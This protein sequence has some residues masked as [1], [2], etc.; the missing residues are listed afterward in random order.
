MNAE[1]QLKVQALVDGELPPNEA[2]QVEALLAGD[3][4]ARQLAA[5]LKATRD[6]LRDNEPPLA[7]PESREFYWSKIAREIE[8]LEAQNAQPVPTPWLR[9]A[10]RWLL[11]VGGVAVLAGLL[12]MLSASR[13]PA[14]SANS[15]RMMPGTISFYLQDEDVTIV[16]IETGVNSG[17]TD[18]SPD[19]SVAVE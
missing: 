3:A 14:L 19:G 13:T 1:T 10:R 2:A 6:A 11:P 12:A 9:W 5:S 8:R 15:S 7:V 4:G 16:W 18:A 17:F